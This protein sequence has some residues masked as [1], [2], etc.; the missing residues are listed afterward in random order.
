MSSK[1][2]DVRLLWSFDIS[3]SE[4]LKGKYE[5]IRVIELLL[6]DIA[7]RGAVSRVP[8]SAGPPRP[9]WIWRKYVQQVGEAR[10]AL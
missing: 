8:R 3:W 4:A 9:I 1:R 7:C 2:H 6:D 5:P 10:R